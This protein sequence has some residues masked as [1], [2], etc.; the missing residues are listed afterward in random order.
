MPQ[1]LVVAKRHFQKWSHELRLSTPQ[2]LPVQATAGLFVQR[3][4]HRICAAIRDAGLWFHQ[5]SVAE[6]ADPN[7]NGFDRRCSIPTLAN[8]IWLT[9]ETRVDRDQAAFAQVTW[10]ITSQL[11]LNGGLRYFT[12][13]NTLEGFYGYSPACICAGSGHGEV[14]RAGHRPLRALHRLQQSR[15]GSGNV[16]RLNLTYKFTPDK[17]VYATC[18]KGFRPGGVNRTAQAASDLIRPT[19]SRTTRSAGRRSGSI[20]AC[21]GTARCS[22]GLE[23][24]PVFVPRTQ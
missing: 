17:M 6:F 12:S 2:D 1:E 18:S 7:P 15:D 9:D 4:L 22:R 16:P 5:P 20:T 10:D 11:S 13:D 3:Q 21:V 8:T 24:F 14:L 19:S 23:E